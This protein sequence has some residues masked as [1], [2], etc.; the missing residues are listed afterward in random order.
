MT[1]RNFETDGLTELLRTKLREHPNLRALS[2][3][4]GVSLGA[5]YNLKNK[6]D[7]HCSMSFA[8]AVIPFIFEGKTLAIVGQ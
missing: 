3:D 6:D 2:R 5:I 7:S 8:S 4:A 1:T